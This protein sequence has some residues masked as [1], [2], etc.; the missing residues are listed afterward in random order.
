MS[1]RPVSFFALSAAAA[2][3]IACGGA[4]TP[5][6]SPCMS[7]REC[8]GDRICHAG[9]CRF[10]EE[11]LAELRAGGSDP[12]EGEP[13]VEDGG[14]TVPG[15]DGGRAAPPA[16]ASETTAL[17]MFMGGPRHTGRT[18]HAGPAT[19]PKLRWSHRTGARIF[20]S[21]VLAPDGTVLVGSLDHSFNAV[22]PDGTLRWRYTAG[23]KIYGSAAIAGDGTI[24]VGS[25]DGMFAAFTPRGQLRWRLE[26]GGEVDSSPAIGDDGT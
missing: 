3:L 8:Q 4:Q 14:A 10:Q 22:A 15:P 20:A 17:P 5:G 23:A 11:V 18:E 13:A 2:W 26:L 19:A 6:S 24:Y 1:F 12:A 21:P 16:P 25:D 9:Q 7:D